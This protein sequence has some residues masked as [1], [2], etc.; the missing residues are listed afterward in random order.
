MWQYA[1]LDEAEQAMLRAGVQRFIE[2]KN[3]EGCGGLELTDEM[4]VTIAA[5][6][7][8][9]IL[10]LDSDSYDHVMSVLVYPDAYVAPE[11]SAGPGGLVAER[12][13][14]RA[15]EAWQD[16]A[17]VLSWAEVQAGIGDRGSGRNV[18]IH[19]FAH[20]LDMLNRDV[21]GT[22]PLDDG[23]HVD[24]WRQVMAAVYERLVGEVERGRHTFLDAYGATNIAELF[25][26]ASECFF[27]TPA[28][29]RRQE[30]ALYAMFCQYYRQDL[31]AR[32][33]T[34]PDRHT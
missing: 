21:D 8:L 20:E 32:I 17:V 19:E 13:S 28:E 30:Y 34:P 6:A 16:G 3:W 24:S 29:M 22:P 18:V 12:R 31:A 7:T 5:Y 9:P 1:L 2:D 33:E 26:V 25:A 4:K 11:E 14:A 27:E 10:E 23:D 15:G